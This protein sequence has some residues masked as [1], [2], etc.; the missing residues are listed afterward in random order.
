MTDV[1]NR[2]LSQPAYKKEVQNEKS[3]PQLLQ[4]PHTALMDLGNSYLWK[5]SHI[6][7]RNRKPCL[8][9]SLSKVKVRK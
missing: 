7:T 1:Y 5:S 4:P 3:T 2:L 9:C 8:A 6:V